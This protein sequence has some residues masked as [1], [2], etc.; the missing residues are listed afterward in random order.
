MAARVSSRPL[1][2]YMAKNTCDMQTLAAR[3]GVS[4]SSIHRWILSDSMPIMVALALKGLEKNKYGV[5]ATVNIPPKEIPRFVAFME[6]F[7]YS[8]SIWRADNEQNSNR[9]S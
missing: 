4:R 9:R 7:E 6:A 5:L 8:Y 2:N 1:A 3:L